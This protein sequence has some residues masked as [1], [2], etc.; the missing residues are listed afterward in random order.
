MVVLLR[1]NLVLDAL[2][3]PFHSLSTLTQANML[4]PRSHSTSVKVVIAPAI[5]RDLLEGYGAYF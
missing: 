5:N 1:A 3:T 2:S 4:G